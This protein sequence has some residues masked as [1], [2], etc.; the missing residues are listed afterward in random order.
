MQGEGP[1]GAAGPGKR[2]GTGGAQA[3]MDSQEG[4]WAG[5]PWPGGRAQDMAQCLGLKAIHAVSTLNVLQIW[6]PLC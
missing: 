1:V 2:V 3:G 5:S 4:T 6:N